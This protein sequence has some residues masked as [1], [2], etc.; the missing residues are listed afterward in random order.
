[1]GERFFLRTAMLRFYSCFLFLG[2]CTASPFEALS[3]VPVVSGLAA[4]LQNVFPDS[5]RLA[6]DKAVASGLLRALG[7]EGVDLQEVTCNRDYSRLCPEGW[8]EAGDGNA[9]LAPLDYQG[10]CAP[11]LQMGGLTGQQKRLQAGR[12][13][14]SYSLPRR[15]HIGCFTSLPPRMA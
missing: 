4:Q 12:C 5:P 2:F 13:G 9:C 6:I 11:M 15:L 3:K 14:A 8:A 10:P 1:M 7:D